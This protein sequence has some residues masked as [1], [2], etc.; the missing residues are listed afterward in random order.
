M[1]GP[2]YLVNPM[3]IKM[4]PN[5]KLRIIVDASSPHDRDEGVPSWIWNP[6]LPGSVNSTIDVQKFPARMSSVTKFVRTLWKVGRGA[7]VCKI[8]WSSAYKHQHV[9]KED[10][11]LQAFEWG[12]RLFVEMMLIFGGKSS[13]GIYDDLAKCFLGCVCNIS[14]LPRSQVEHHLMMSCGWDC[15]ERIPWFMLS[16]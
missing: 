10:L 8:D 14:G 7:L 2:D 11:K 13:P 4:K 3:G 12:G 9:V 6:L 1:L 15:L 16:S 5:G